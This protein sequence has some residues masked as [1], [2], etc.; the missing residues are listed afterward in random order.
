ME[1]GLCYRHCDRHAPRVSSEYDSASGL[2]T[3]F[4]STTPSTTCVLEIIQNSKVRI[5][6]STQHHTPKT[7]PLPAAQGC[8][9][10]Q[11][12]TPVISAR[13]HCASVSVNDGLSMTR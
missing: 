4:S 2:S 1:Q 3:L 9:A 12:P 11:N 13:W 10:L 8:A 6:C 7:E 5:H